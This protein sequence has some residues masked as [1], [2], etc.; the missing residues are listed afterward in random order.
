MKTLLAFSGGIDSIYLL[1]KELRET[2]DEITAVFYTGERIDTDMR[3]NFNVLNVEDRKFADVRWVQLKKIVEAISNEIRTFNFIRE[4]L[5]PKFLDRDI[6]NKNI[7]NH[8]ASLRVAMAVEHINAGIYDKFAVGTAIDNDG[9]P[10]NKHGFR[11]NESASSLITKYFKKN[12]KRGELYMPFCDS[13]YT[14]A[15]AI[16][17]LPDWLTAMNRSCQLMYSSS[18]NACNHCYKCMTHEYARNLLEEGKSPEE[19]YDIYMQKSIKPD[20]TWRS[21]QVWIA[22]EVPCNI[23]S[24]INTMPMPQWGHSVKIGE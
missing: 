8:A 16:K 17:E 3:N 21:Q 19:I 12:A 20:G 13:K 4:A 2:D 7:F 14:V 24:P 15:E 6:S 10:I 23:S 9:F 18:V 11:A 22:E 1:W 5:D